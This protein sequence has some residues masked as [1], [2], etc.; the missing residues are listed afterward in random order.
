[1]A[2]VPIEHVKVDLAVR[3]SQ[4][5]SVPTCCRV[6]LAY[7]TP[8]PK[9]LQPREPRG[10]SLYNPAILATCLFCPFALLAAAPASPLTPL[11]SS[12]P[13]STWLSLARSRPL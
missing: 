1:M 3:F 6:C 13:L 11:P 5:P 4:T 2:E 9:L 10:S 7:P 8:Y 12:P